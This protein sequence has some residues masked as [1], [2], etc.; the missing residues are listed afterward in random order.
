MQGNTTGIPA[1]DSCTD[2]RLVDLCREFIGYL[3]TVEESDSGREFHPTTIQSCRCVVA[4]R[5]GE[6]I[7]EIKA[8]CENYGRTD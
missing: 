7:P 4:A 1:P 5:L 2:S 6:I 8:I 3:E